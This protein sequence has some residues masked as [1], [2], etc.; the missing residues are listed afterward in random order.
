MLFQ[1]ALMDF[2]TYNGPFNSTV[3][4]LISKPEGTVKKTLDTRNFGYEKLAVS[5]EA[6]IGTKLVCLVL[7][8]FCM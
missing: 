1:A 8:V 4:P 7:G 2:L 6:W 3:K 5:L